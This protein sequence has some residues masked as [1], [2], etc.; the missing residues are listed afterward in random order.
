MSWLDFLNLS[1]IVN[2][3]AKLLNRSQCL[4]FCKRLRV[5]QIWYV[6]LLA[7]YHSVRTPYYLLLSCLLLLTRGWS[8]RCG[9]LSQDSRSAAASQLSCS[10]PPP[11]CYLGG[12]STVPSILILRN[13]SSIL[14]MALTLGPS[15]HFRMVPSFPLVNFVPH[16]IAWQQCLRKLV[17][18]E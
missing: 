18:S 13:S 6:Q 9:R 11:Q 10:W 3:F 7:N 16:P 8:E 15:N 17:C 2:W 1:A 4:C 12:C 5:F 14:K